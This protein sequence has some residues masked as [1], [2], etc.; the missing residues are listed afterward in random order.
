DSYAISSGARDIIALSVETGARINELN[1]LRWAD[2]NLD[3]S[4][5]S[6]TFAGQVVRRKGEGLEWTPVLKS[7]VSYRTIPLTE[8]AVPEFERRL[9]AMRARHRDRKSTRLNS[10]HVSISYAVFCLK[11]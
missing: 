3:S 4:P 7:A 1:S 5:P 10:S 9:E 6:L 8:P 2:I 11:K